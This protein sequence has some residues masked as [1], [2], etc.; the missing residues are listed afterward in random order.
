LAGAFFAAVFF[1]GAFL[2]GAFFALVAVVAIV[3]GRTFPW[4]MIE[5]HDKS[6][7]QAVSGSSGVAEVCHA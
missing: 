6:P 1:A 2:A 4:G 3:S 5:S 7:S